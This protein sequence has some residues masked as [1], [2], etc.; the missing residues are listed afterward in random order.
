M[1]QSEEIPGFGY[2]MPRLEPGFGS[3]AQLVGREDQPSLRIT[4]AIARELISAF[5]ALHA[6]GLCYRDVSFGNLCVD[7]DRAQIAII[8][9]DNARY[10]DP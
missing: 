2:V 5:Q 4:I 3:F 10:S 8:D 6:Y 9:N 7:L 1:V